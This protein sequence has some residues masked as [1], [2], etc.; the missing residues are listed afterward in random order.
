LIIVDGLVESV[1]TLPVGSLL[2]AD[3]AT[4]W[5]PERLLHDGHV[6]HHH[7]LLAHHHARGPRRWRPSWAFIWRAAVCLRAVPFAPAAGLLQGLA[8]LVLLAA[9]VVGLDAWATGSGT[10]M[11]AAVEAVFE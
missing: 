1:R 11:Q 4:G 8:A 9:F 3:P 6:I 7:G 5:P 10:F 2:V